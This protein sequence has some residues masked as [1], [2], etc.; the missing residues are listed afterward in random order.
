MTSRPVVE[1]RPIGSEAVYHLNSMGYR[2]GKRVYEKFGDE[3]SIND[4]RVTSFV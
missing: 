1:G 2:S 4:Y 3:R